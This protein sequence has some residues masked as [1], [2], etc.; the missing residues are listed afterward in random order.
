MTYTSLTS[1]RPLENPPARSR[2]RQ[3]LCPMLLA[4]PSRR[5]LDFV[6]RDPGG[7]PDIPVYV[8]RASSQGH[9]HPHPRPRRNGVLISDLLPNSFPRDSTQTILRFCVPDEPGRCRPK[10]K[11]LRACVGSRVAGVV[12]PPRP[13]PPLPGLAPGARER[14]WEPRCRPARGWAGAHGAGWG[15][16]NRRGVAAQAGRTPQGEAGSGSRLQV[17]V[18]K[19]AHRASRAATAAAASSSLRLDLRV[20]DM[21]TWVL[22]TSPPAR[23]LSSTEPRLQDPEARDLGLGRPRPTAPP[24]GEPTPSPTKPPRVT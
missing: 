6:S 16:G 8:E 1:T 7:S 9:P 24:P 17:R 10:Q 5:K 12:P 18:R 4:R 22:P 23:G 15:C 19:T 14:A 2:W 20:C 21:G 3:H 13:N 11:H